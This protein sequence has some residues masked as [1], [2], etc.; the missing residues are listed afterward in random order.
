MDSQN[1]FI[2]L[3]EIVFKEKIEF[4]KLVTPISIFTGINSNYISSENAFLSNISPVNLSIGIQIRY[5]SQYF[6]TWA[7]VYCG[8]YKLSNAS[9]TKLALLLSKE[10]ETDVSIS[11]PF[12]LEYPNPSEIIIC[13]DGS[14]CEAYIEEKEE[15]VEECT[16]VLET[17]KKECREGTNKNNISE[18]ILELENIEKQENKKYI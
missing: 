17:Y 7:Q 15:E 9:L 1:Y 13:P 4:D 18:L 8:N 14:Y 11:N 6:K 16:C 2:E 12:Y 3:Y 5:Q 10:L